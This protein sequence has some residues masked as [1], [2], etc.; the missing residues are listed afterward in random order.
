MLACARIKVNT[1]LRERAKEKGRKTQM[2]ERKRERETVERT[3]GAYGVVRTFMIHK[4][5]A[6]AAAATVSVSE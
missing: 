5:N 2:K 1:E 3:G 4:K 6:A